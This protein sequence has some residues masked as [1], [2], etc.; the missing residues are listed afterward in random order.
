M[1]K[2]KRFSAIDRSA[3]AGMLDPIQVKLKLTTQKRFSHPVN[4]QSP[5]L[6]VTRMLPTRFE[7]SNRSRLKTD[8]ALDLRL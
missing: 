3:G 8:P 1:I 5:R 7:A 2:G 4:N 6:M